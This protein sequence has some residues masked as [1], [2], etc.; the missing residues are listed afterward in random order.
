MDQVILC[1]SEA[2]T[3]DKLTNVAMLVFSSVVNVGITCEL[4]EYDSPNEVLT[5]ADLAKINEDMTRRRQEIMDDLMPYASQVIKKHWNKMLMTKS[6]KLGQIAE[7]IEL[8]TPSHP[9]SISEGPIWRSS[10]ALTSIPR[11]S[12]SK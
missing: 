12:S 1:L 4:T 7:R 3:P 2:D 11:L 6:I 5:E 10:D 8:E 9:K